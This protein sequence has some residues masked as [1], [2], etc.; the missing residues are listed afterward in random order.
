MNPIDHIPLQ[1]HGADRD[2][3]RII[4]KESECNLVM[5]N[6]CRTFPIIHNKGRTPNRS[7]DIDYG[8]ISSDVNPM[9]STLKALELYS[10]GLLSSSVV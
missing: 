4:S 8:G 6:R 3:H 5:I 10:L 9:E 7:L 2:I 1:P